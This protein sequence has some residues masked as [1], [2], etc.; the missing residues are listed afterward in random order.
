MKSDDNPDT[1]FLRNRLKKS[2]FA[3]TRGYKLIFFTVDIDEI[4]IT[5]YKGSQNHPEF[6]FTQ[7]DKYWDGTTVSD[8]KAYSYRTYNQANLKEDASI[9][10]ELTVSLET[11]FTIGYNDTVIWIEYTKND[12]EILNKEIVEHYFTRSIYLVDDAE[13]RQTQVDLSEYD[14][15]AKYV[16]IDCWMDFELPETFLEEAFTSLYS[17]SVVNFD[18]LGRH[19]IWLHE[20]GKQKEFSMTLSDRISQKYPETCGSLTYEM[21]I[22]D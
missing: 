16:L 7:Q 1:I 21:E 14:I 3:L 8:K 10:A 2:D 4:W 17:D 12:L 19:F 13:I 22:I 6:W 15:L 20:K 18:G 9:L 5:D 11:H